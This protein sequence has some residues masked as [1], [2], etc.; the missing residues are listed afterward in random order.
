MACS[1]NSPHLHHLNIFK[2][3][4]EDNV[5]LHAKRSAVVF[6]TENAPGMTI[7][8]HKTG[9]VSHSAFK[10]RNPVHSLKYHEIEPGKHSNQEQGRIDAFHGQTHSHNKRHRS[11][12]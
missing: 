3:N 8:L 10:E 11:P 1:R 7:F 2:R 5:F 12:N 9:G 6:G 4:K